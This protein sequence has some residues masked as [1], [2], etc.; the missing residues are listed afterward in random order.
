V[1]VLVE[2]QVYGSGEGRS[3]QMATKLA[4]QDA[5]DHLVSNSHNGKPT[6]L[7]NE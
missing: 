1:D 3:K 4:A 2:G 7:T 6:R 5:L